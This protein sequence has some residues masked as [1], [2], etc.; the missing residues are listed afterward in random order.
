MKK[1]GSPELEEKWPAAAAML[2]KLNFNNAQIAAAA[3]MVDV[4][5]LSPEDAADKWLA[6][7]EEVWSAWV[8]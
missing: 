3:A 2:K 4:D 6:D 7:N 8:Q 5:G 1:A